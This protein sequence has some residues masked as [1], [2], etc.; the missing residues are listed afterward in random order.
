ML[1]EVRIAAKPEIVVEPD[2]HAVVKLSVES[3]AVFLPFRVAEDGPASVF[4][5]SL[6]ETVHALGITAL[7]LGA[8][9][10]ELASEP[11]SGEYAQMAEAVDTAEKARKHADKT[12]VDAAKAAENAQKGAEKVEKERASGAESSDIAELETDARTAEDEAERARRR[13]AKAKVKADTA[14]EEAETITGQPVKKKDEP[15]EDE[16]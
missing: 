6:E 4:G 10:I 11:E 15:A 3:S 14:E 1:D 12:E 13:A 5:G 7:V 8:Q 9:D 16:S 2:S